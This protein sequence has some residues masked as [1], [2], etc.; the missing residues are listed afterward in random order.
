MKNHRPVGFSPFRQLELLEQQVDSWFQLSSIT[1]ASLP[2]LSS[3]SS[4]Y[5]SYYPPHQLPG[6]A[7]SS[8]SCPVTRGQIG[9]DLN[10]STSHFF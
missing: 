5:S 7:L 4:S 10:T 6:H 9:F 1:F 3:S 8:L 2:Q